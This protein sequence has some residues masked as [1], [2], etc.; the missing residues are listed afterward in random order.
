MKW[1]IKP[2]ATLTGD[3]NKDIQNMHEYLVNLDRTLANVLNNN[4]DVENMASDLRNKIYTID[5]INNKI[6]ANL[7]S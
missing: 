4:I 1:S 3:M 7:S 5:E 6:R 2:P